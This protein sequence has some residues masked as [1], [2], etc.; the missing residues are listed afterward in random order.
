MNRDEFDAGVRKLFEN[1]NALLARKN[2]KKEGGNGIYD[3]YMY[4]IITRD[5]PIIM[6]VTDDPEMNV[7]DIRLTRHEDGWIAD[8]DGTVFVYYAS[9]DTRMH[10][11]TTTMEKLIDY[12]LNTPEDA[13]R[14]QLC[15]ARRDQMIK[16]NLKILSENYPD[17]KF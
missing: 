7:Y 11:A 17:I 9:S 1:H 3:R 4:P 8:E 6:P 10:V 12:V 14:T 15:T 5:H 2:I 16:K 13:G